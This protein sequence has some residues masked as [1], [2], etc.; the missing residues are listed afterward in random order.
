MNA[1]VNRNSDLFVALE[2]KSADVE[3]ALTQMK[4]LLSKLLSNQPERFNM[5]PP[6]PA[7]STTGHEQEP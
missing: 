4:D 1:S 3:I 2:A 6:Q 7:A 5:T